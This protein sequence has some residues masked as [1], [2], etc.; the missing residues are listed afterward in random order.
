[1]KFLDYRQHTPALLDVTKFYSKVIKPIYSFKSS[2]WMFLFSHIFQHTW[3]NQH[4][5]SLPIRCV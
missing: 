5:G 2:E 4:L 3:H 1:M